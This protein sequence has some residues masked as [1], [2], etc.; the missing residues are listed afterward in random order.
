M[1]KRRELER[2]LQAF[3]EI[4]EILGAMKNLALMEMGK[5]TR[6][7]S[8]QQRV[9]EGIETVAADLL[10]FYPEMPA[11]PGKARHVWLLIGSERGFCGD[12]NEAVK[13]VFN[14][15]GK[16][17][18]T[19]EA[20]VIAVGYRL[21]SKLADDNRVTTHLA[22]ASVVEEVESVLT[23]VME[24][25]AALQTEHP[26]LCPLCLTLFSHRLDETQVQ[27]LV[28]EPFRRLEKKPARFA[29]APLLNLSPPAFFAGLA[30]H[31]LFAKLHELFYSSLMV[32]N[33]RRLQH[34]ENAL[35]RIEQESSRLLLRRN[36]LRQ[37]EITEEI[38]VL[39][40]SAE[41]LQRPTR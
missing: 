39:L 37:E 2:E 25:L 27:A 14:A 9:V 15:Y 30:E 6:F 33:Q 22:G 28:L 20:I 1:S 26:A 40:L 18:A 3:G 19:E 10:S 41:A 11:A 13:S 7:I 4:R 24:M 5:L 12:F 8:T 38:E 21:S 35:H 17:F 36:S 34:M 31:Y 29:Y 16:R 32:E 23:R